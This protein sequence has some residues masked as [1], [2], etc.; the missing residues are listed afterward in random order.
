MPR[1]ARLDAPGALHHVMVRGIEGRRIFR[2]DRDRD[3]FIQRLAR[4]VPATGLT[5]YAWALLP[6]HIHLLIRTGPR[7]LAR[8]M[9]SLLTGYAGAFNRRHHRH[10]HLFQ[11]RYKSIVVEQDPYFLELVRY[12]HLNPLRAGLVNDLKALDRYPWTGHSA[13]MDGIDRLWQAVPEVLEQFGPRREAA[14]RRYR[15][16]VAAGIPQGRKPEL[17]GGGLVRSLGG[18]SAVQELR[19]GRE[20]YTSDER[21]LGG[22]DF[23][24]ALL[25]EIEGQRR[26]IRSAPALDEI[27]DRVCEATGLRPEALRGTGRTATACRSREGVA[28]IWVEAL[29]QSGRILALA[30]GVRPPSIYRAAQ[31]GREARPRWERILASIK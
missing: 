23:V 16:F 20:S 18:W 11:N 31:R 4:L 3:D 12:I 6:N 10:G 5:V 25:N 9:R 21:I 15:Q 1:G 30:L 28:Y 24:A 26:P 17:Q 13:I 27:I 29:G 7:P 19:R 2:D 8:I 14:R 22:S